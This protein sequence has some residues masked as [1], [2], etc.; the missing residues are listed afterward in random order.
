[1]EPIQMPVMGTYFRGAKAQARVE[2]LLPQEPLFLFAESNNE[3]DSYAI[4]VCATKNPW[5]QDQMNT[6]LE[7]AKESAFADP[8]HIPDEEMHIG[9]VPKEQAAYLQPELSLVTKCYF[10][11]HEADDKGT[12][13]AQF[14]IVLA[15][16]DS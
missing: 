15:D 11:K 7:L 6:H 14:A 9:Y 1:M 8:H 2:E 13:R 4:K 3:Y 10:V 12:V 5:E 16:A